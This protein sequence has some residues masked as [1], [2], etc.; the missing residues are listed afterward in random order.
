MSAEVTPVSIGFNPLALRPRRASAVRRETETCVFPTPVPVPTMAMRVAMRRTIE[1]PGDEAQK[2][3]YLF[4]V[5]QAPR[6]EAAA[7]STWSARSM[8]EAVSEAVAVTR[9]RAVS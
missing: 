2:P 4:H 3:R 8:S 1:R 6:Q 9:R 7:A 5:K